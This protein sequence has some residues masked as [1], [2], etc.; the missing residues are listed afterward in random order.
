MS[1]LTTL[2]RQTILNRVRHGNI[3]TTIWKTPSPAFGGELN[4]K[5]GPTRKISDDVLE[6]LKNIFEVTGGQDH[7]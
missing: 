2:T 1:S 6:E 5:E 7:L 4:G 3:I